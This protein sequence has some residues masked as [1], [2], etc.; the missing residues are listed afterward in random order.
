MYDFKSSLFYRAFRLCCLCLRSQVVKLKLKALH[1]ECE[2]KLPDVTCQYAKKVKPCIEHVETY[3][4]FMGHRNT[5]HVTIS[6]KTCHV[7]IN[8]NMCLKAAPV[9]ST[10]STFFFWEKH[11]TMTSM[12]PG[13]CGLFHG[14]PRG[15]PPAMP[16]LT[17]KKPMGRVWGVISNY[18]PWNLSL[19]DRHVPMIN[20]VTPPYNPN[21]SHL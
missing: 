1:T 16:R 9:A 12:R 2:K 11:F 7:K 13:W 17:P 8:C 21:I 15:P 10:P 19:Q 3:N 18:N 6:C 20:E 5:V 4:M 14:N